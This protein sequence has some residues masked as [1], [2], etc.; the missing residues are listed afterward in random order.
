MGKIW[1]LSAH[2]WIGFVGHL[3]SGRG[4]PEQR[5]APAQRINQQNI[6]GGDE[7]LSRSSH[8]LIPRMTVR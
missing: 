1:T 6:A 3:T 4:L 2:R 5:F 7:H 8:G